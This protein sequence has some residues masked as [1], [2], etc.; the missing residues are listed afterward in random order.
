MRNIAFACN[1]ETLE[2]SLV[3]R[4]IEF[5]KMFHANTRFVHVSEVSH[6]GDYELEELLLEQIVSKKEPT[7]E[8]SVHIVYDAKV[9]EG[10][11]EYAEREAIDL[12]IL[13]TKQ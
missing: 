7:L 11:Y 9:W 3:D 12:I 5:A 10:L 8:C 13:A 4:V 2:Q 6:Q 1:H